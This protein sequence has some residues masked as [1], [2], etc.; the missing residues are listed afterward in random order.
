MVLEPL[1]KAD[2]LVDEVSFSCE[3]PD[4]RSTVPNCEASLFPFYGFEKASPFG[5]WATGTND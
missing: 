2:F 1:G 4:D 5:C 3:S